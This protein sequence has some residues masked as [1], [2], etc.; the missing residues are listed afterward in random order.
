M[1]DNLDQ[2]AAAPAKN[3]EVAGV[4][5]ASKRLLHLQGKTLHPATHIRPADRQPD[6]DL[7]WY[8]DHETPSALTIAA[9]SV[10]G[11]VGGIRSRTL[12][13]ISSS[14]IAAGAAG[15]AGGEAGDRLN[16]DDDNFGKTRLAGSHRA[17]PLIDQAGR[18]IL[19][20]RHRRHCGSRRE[21]HG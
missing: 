9:A 4:R 17:A 12:P 11:V 5:V 15:A 2:I 18:N 7:A 20:T 16:G 1:P 13:A 10:G 14:I 21:G 3:I 8:R 19:L 6:P